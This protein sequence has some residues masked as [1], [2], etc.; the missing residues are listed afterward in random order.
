MSFWKRGGRVK[1]RESY[2]RRGGAR[3]QEEGGRVRL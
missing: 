1:G 3:P 2:D